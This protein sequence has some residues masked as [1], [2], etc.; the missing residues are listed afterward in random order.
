MTG[1]QTKPFR[2]TPASDLTGQRFG[3]LTVLGRAESERYERKGRSS[4]TFATWLCRCDC[5]NTTTVR[6]GNLRSGNSCTCGQAE[7]QLNGRRK[8]RRPAKSTAEVKTVDAGASQGGAA[9]ISCLVCGR[10]FK[11]LPTHLRL[12]HEVTV[13]AYREAFD[14]PAGLPLAGDDYRA[15]HAEKIRRMQAAG[16]LTY[17]HLRDATELAR[18]AGRGRRSNAELAQQSERIR[19]TA[20]WVEKTL[21]PGSKR[22]DGRDADRA[23]EYQREYRRRR[24]D[25]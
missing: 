13:D 21:P 25:K 20:P 15:A 12:A 17:E 14:I 24:A 19:S 11:F 22:S 16:T 18:S 3:H 6:A 5:G 9:R 1:R 2:G 10:L 4:M 7:C 23:R 8:G